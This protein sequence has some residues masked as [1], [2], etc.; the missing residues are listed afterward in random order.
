VVI[1][2]LACRVDGREVIESIKR[3]ASEGHHADWLGMLEERCSSGRLMLCSA[4]RR[5]LMCWPPQPRILP[6]VLRLILWPAPTVRAD[7]AETGLGWLHRSKC[8]TCASRARKRAP[9]ELAG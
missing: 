6:A 7:M 5:E 2:D 1:T 3:I 9:I 8:M 4:S